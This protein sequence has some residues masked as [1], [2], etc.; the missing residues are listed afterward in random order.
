MPIDDKKSTLPEDQ[1]S[2]LA[3]KHRIKPESVNDLVI[4][5]EVWMLNPTF[6]NA[7]DAQF[8]RLI[9]RHRDNG[10]HHTAGI[11]WFVEA[12]KRR[13]LSLFEAADILIALTKPGLV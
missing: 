9:M 10:Q 11:I 12:A 4:Q 7:D 13:G 6:E 2:E 1:V 8:L 5:L 3:H